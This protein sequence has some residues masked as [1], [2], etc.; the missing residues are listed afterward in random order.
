[1][2]TAKVLLTAAQANL[3]ERALD[4]LLMDWK[5]DGRPARERD[6]WR[7]I[8]KKLDRAAAEANWERVDPRATA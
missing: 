8:V 2:K 3:I 4:N 6:L 5:H 1:M 7:Q